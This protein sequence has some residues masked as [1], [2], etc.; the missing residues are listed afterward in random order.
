MRRFPLRKAALVA[1][2]MASLALG[3]IGV[4]VPL[5]PATVFL[6]ISAACFLR[7]SERL[8]RWL[9]THRLF[10][11]YIRNYR[12]HRAMPAR[13][14]AFVLVLLWSTIGYSMVFAVDSILIR[15]GLAVVAIGVTAHV[16]SLR[17]PPPEGRGEA[18]TDFSPVERVT[19]P[20]RLP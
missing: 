7:S 11:P 8:Y 10:G 17:S 2:G 14:K 18:A 12:E 15:L 1:A 20:S 4:F 9:M 13:T 19:S 6:L 5:M 3:A 16:L